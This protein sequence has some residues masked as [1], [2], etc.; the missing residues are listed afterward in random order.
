MKMRPK[1]RDENCISAKN[2][3]ER[4]RERGGRFSSVKF[5]RR[6]KK[7]IHGP[8]HLAVPHAS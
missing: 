7:Q 2:K 3:R 6:W 8:L 1:C 4:E 5:W